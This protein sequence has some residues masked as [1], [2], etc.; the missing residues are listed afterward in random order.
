MERVTAPRHRVKVRVTASPRHRAA[1]PGRVMNRVAD[2]C[3]A[4][5]IVDAN[6]KGG[7]LR[8]ERAA[9]IA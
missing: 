2:A 7:R 9:L 8:L 4:E 6:A 5:A 1:S 3:S